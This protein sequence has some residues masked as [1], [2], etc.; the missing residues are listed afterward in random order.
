MAKITSFQTE[1]ST[2]LCNC[3]RCGQSF[4]AHKATDYCP[5][6]AGIL[7]GEQLEEAYEQ[8]AEQAVL[9]AIL[10]PFPE[11][12]LA[13]CV[14]ELVEEGNQWALQA[15]IDDPLRHRFAQC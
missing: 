14:A 11:D 4:K 8:A 7:Y 1:E 10:P 6:C 13:E 2:V 3:A 5:E 9:D 12:K 15:S